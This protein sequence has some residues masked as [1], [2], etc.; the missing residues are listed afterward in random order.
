M[1]KKIWTLID[2]LNELAENHPV[3][4]PIVNSIIASSI[5]TIIIILLKKWLLSKR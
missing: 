5:T 2:K 1:N 3:L 4:V